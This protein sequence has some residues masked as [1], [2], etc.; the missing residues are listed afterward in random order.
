MLKD[1][2]NFVM[3]GNIVDLA[4]AFVL[5]TAF[6]L[7][8]KALVADMFTPLL[9]IPGH[10][11]FANLSFKVGGGIFHYGDFINDVIEFIVIAAALFFLVV[12]PM[13]AAQ[14][15]AK[16]RQGDVPPDTKTCPECLSTVP[17]LATR[18]AFCTAELPAAA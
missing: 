13:Q 11:T 3:R 16:R 5:G 14:A 2:K 6:A 10:I 18:C 15:R 12:Q 9:S 4:I 8:V 7:V 17:Y 1:F